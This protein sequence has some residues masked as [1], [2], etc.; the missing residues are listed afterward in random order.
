MIFFLFPMLID[1]LVLVLLFLHS[2]MRAMCSLKL[3][4]CRNIAEL[5]VL[6]AFRLFFSLCLGSFYVSFTILFGYCGAQG[7]FIYNHIQYLFSYECCKA[8]FDAN[9][10]IFD[11]QLSNYYDCGQGKASNRRTNLLL[12]V[13][14]SSVLLAC[15]S[16]F[17]V[18]VDLPDACETSTG[19]RQ[20]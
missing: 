17:L 2:M 11:L 4:K 6:Q 15:S 16:Y 12:H 9:I 5:K 19:S 7:L 8:F 3:G 1:S 20:A 14:Y 18:G 13:Q 10:L